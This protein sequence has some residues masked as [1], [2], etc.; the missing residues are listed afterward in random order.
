MR[1]PSPEARTLPRTQSLTVASALLAY[2][3]RL[4]VFC[5]HFS[6]SPP[7]ADV[8]DITQVAENFGDSF[9]GV[10][11]YNRDNTAFEVCA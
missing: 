10:V 4:V 6:I 8:L 9:M 5:I 7:L 11:Q 2:K 1:T 3:Y